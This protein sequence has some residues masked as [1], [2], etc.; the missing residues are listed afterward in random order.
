MHMSKPFYSS[1]TVYLLLAG[2]LLFVNIKDLRAQGN[3]QTNFYALS[4]KWA[5]VDDIKQAKYMMAELKFN[6]TLYMCRYY[7]MEGPMIFQQSYSD[8]ELTVKNGY[9]AWYNSS[10]R[11]DSMGMYI[12]NLKEGTWRHAINDS[13]KPNV[14]KYYQHGELK[15]VIDFNARQ[16]TGEHGEMIPASFDSTLYDL[17]E[18][19]PGPVDKSA[20]YKFDGIPGWGSYLAE[21]LVTPERFKKIVGRSKNEYVGVLFFVSATGKIENVLIS[22]SREISVDTEATR[23]VRASPNW[24]PATLNH[25]NIPFVHGQR[26]TFNIY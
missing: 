17:R 9:F 13:I 4:E 24:I 25:K 18:M 11:V 20:M 1:F 12:R 14:L 6:D 8:K 16:V 2:L 10:G 19:N 15:Q 23:V 26:I 7:S 21:N 3:F 22:R 5:P